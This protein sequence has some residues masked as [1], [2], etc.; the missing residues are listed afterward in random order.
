MIQRGCDIVAR[1]GKLVEFSTVGKVATSREGGDL[2]LAT[3]EVST[4]SANSRVC[5]ELLFPSWGELPT[6]RPF[7]LP[8]ALHRGLGS[9]S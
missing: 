7:E 9:G 8:G 1:P 5:D 3:A 2:I 6:R 4:V